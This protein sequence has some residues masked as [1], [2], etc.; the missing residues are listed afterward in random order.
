MVSGVPLLTTRL[1]GIP[2]EYFEFVHIFKEETIDGYRESM[3]MILD[4]PPNELNLFGARAKKFILENKNN[5][6]QAEKFYKVFS[7]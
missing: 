3:E 6:M 7:N 5:R 2:Q 4:V 1:P